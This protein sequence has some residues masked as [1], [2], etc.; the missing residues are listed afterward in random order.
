MQP[1]NAVSIRRWFDQLADADPAV[2]E[3]AADNLMRLNR[4]DLPL[5]RSVVKDE[6]PLAPNQVDLL[7]GIVSQIYLSG[8]EYEIQPGAGFMGIRM[9]AVDI[10][11]HPPQAAALPAPPHARAAAA[12]SV[13]ADGTKPSAVGI[14]VENC[15]PGFCAGGVLHPGDIIV[16]LAGSADLGFANSE[17]FSEGIRAFGP[18]ATVHLQILRH[19][20]LREIALTLCPRPAA[21]LAAEINPGP[22][23]ALTQEREQASDRYWD[24]NFAPLLKEEV[25]ST[26]PPAAAAKAP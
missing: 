4:D 6:L 9:F 20:Q 7:P 8:E 14:R 5:L 21:T 25:S 3:D 26:L 12:P 19:G 24:E 10:T 22:M 23:L 16:S 11:A 18:G 17:V 2:R 1:A 13:A 15:I